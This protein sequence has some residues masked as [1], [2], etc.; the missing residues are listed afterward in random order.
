MHVINVVTG[1]IF[2]IINKI[3]DIQY[4]INYYSSELLI[5]LGDVWKLV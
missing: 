3:D 5:T 4:I 1:D 2:K